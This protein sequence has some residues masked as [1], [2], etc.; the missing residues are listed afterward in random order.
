MP[1]GSLGTEC[2]PECGSSFPP[3]VIRFFEREGVEGC[4]ACIRGDL[5]LV[6][7]GAGAPG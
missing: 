6:E 5:E 7:R 1:G 3:W 2:C 4:P